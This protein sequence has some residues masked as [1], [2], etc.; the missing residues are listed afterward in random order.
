MVHIFRVW[1]R[2]GVCILTVTLVGCANAEYFS[3]VRPS[4]LGGS[5]FVELT[6]TAQ[7]SGC[8]CGYASMITVA[9]YYGVSPKLLANDAIL[10]RVGDKDLSANNLVTIAKAF[11]LAAYAY[12]GSIE[13]IQ[14]NVTK[15]R[16]MMVLL[17]AR[18]RLAPF[19]SFGW[20]TGTVQSIVGQPH[21]VVV[22]GITAEG[23]VIFHDPAQGCVAMPKD[24]FRKSWKG[25]S[26]VCVL[27]GRLAST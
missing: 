6:P 9:K 19:P 25:Q 2:V 18:P 15:N 17:S 5:S 1:S 16:P 22:V 24:E 8:K 14:Q 20:A 13:D 12:Q 21:W 27:V 23:K 11:D 10:R 7:G 4:G 26:N 3:G